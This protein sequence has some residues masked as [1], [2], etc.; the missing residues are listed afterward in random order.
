MQVGINRIDIFRG[1]VVKIGLG[2]HRVFD[3]E[4]N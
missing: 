1:A 4:L 3:F 2:I